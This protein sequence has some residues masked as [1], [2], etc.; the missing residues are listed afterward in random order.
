MDD[1]ELADQ[2]I[3]RLGNVLV[4]M[5]SYGPLIEEKVQ[6]ILEKA[7]KEGKKEMSTVDINRE[8]GKAMGEDSFLYWAY[9]NDIPVVVPGIM[10][11]AVGSQVWMF[12]QKHSD[13]K[14]NIIEDANLLSGLVFKAEK[15]RSAD[16]WRRSSKTP[17]FVVEPIQ[18]RIRLLLCMSLQPKNLMVV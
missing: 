1:K 10:D 3:H 2:K 4:P 6:G 8:L 9:K 15:V 16:A 17:H 14:L 5:E 11:G 12:S 18:G 7:Y 13:F